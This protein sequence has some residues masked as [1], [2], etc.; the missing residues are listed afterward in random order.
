MAKSIRLTEMRSFYTS[1]FFL[2]LVK[3]QVPENINELIRYFSSH[4][5]VVNYFFQVV[6]VI[7]KVLH[8]VLS[9]GAVLF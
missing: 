6:E 2:F 8:C 3:H 9:F 7:E 4:F 5:F 1:Y